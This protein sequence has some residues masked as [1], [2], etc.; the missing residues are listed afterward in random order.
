ML[1][2]IEDDGIFFIWNIFSYFTIF[3]IT[4]EC[5]FL[6]CSSFLEFSTDRATSHPAFH[7]LDGGRIDFAD[8][9]VRNADTAGIRVIFQISP[10]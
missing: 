6:D 8:F 2:R 5:F 3:S 4:Q 7:P 9:L 1:Y 10:R